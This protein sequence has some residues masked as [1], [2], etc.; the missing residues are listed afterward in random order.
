[1]EPR[2]KRT[3]WA[4]Q[5]ALRLR[6]SWGAGARCFRLGETVDGDVLEH[7]TDERASRGRRLLRERRVSSLSGFVHGYAEAL[8]RLGVVRCSQDGRGDVGPWKALACGV[9]LLLTVGLW[10][11]TVAA[12]GSVVVLYAQD[13][14]SGLPTQWDTSSTEQVERWISNGEYHLLVHRP[15]FTAF[16]IL[17]GRTF[18]NGCFAVDIT[19]R[20][21]SPHVS[22][23]LAFRFRA[24][25][26]YYRFAISGDGYFELTRCSEG[27]SC[28]VI[29]RKR[30]HVLR[31]GCGMTNRLELE[32]DGCHLRCLVNGALLAEITDSCPSSSGSIGIFV[33]TLFHGGV[34]VAFDNI[35]VTQLAE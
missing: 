15:Y 17:L 4:C 29:Y 33:E 23:G 32:A 8:E 12:V 2:P 9:G 35:G 34:H 13:F 10:T 5:E 30:C 1:M 6:S 7:S 19:Q 31:L 27:Q 20:E 28:Y 18:D 24:P 22:Y 16:G 3:R 26:S 21:G 25:N 14:S 11:A